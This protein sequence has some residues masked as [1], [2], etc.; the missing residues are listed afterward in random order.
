VTEPLVA[1][2]RDR[3]LLRVGC[4]SA[5]LSLGLVAALAWPVG[6]WARFAWWFLDHGWTLFDL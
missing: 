5:L 1:V 3:G 6:V 4:G 2:Q